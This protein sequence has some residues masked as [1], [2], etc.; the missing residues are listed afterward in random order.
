ME[1]KVVLQDQFQYYLDHQEDL[2]K[3]H[4]GKF[5]VI[6][7]FE[8]VGSYDT[9]LEAYRDSIRKY[10]LGTFLI[11]ECTPGDKSYTQTFRTRV[12]FR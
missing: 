3:E 8:L 11:Q 12:I 1:K 7:D 2:L 4:D 9:E 6:K 10:E 5:V